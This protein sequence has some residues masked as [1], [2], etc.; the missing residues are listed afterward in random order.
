MSDN[1]VKKTQCVYCNAWSKLGQ[2]HKHIVETVMM[3][4]AG[5]ERKVRVA[6]CDACYK[7]H[8]LGEL[9]L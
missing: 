4:P 5:Y 7:E 9:G 2:Q 1:L 6:V 3:L 8:M